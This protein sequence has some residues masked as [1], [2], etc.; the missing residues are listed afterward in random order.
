MKVFLMGLAM[1]MTV[2]K[3]Q[4]A[5]SNLKLSG[6][7]NMKCK[8][9]ELIYSNGKRPEPFDLNLSSVKL[10]ASIRLVYIGETNLLNNYKDGFYANS[11]NS[12][13]P[14]DPIKSLQFDCGDIA[15]TF[16]FCSDSILVVGCA[17]KRGFTG[18][19]THYAH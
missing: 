5:L 11:L 1:V 12:F 14:E 19:F 18:K 2:S 9:S 16:L 15:S 3:A 4:G 13:F 6:D 17:P 8:M 7:I 10:G